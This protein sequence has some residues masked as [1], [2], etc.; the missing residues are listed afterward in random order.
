M[1]R[2]NERLTAL[3]TEDMS[4]LQAE[5]NELSDLQEIL[6]RLP[7]GLQ[8]EALSDEALTRLREVAADPEELLSGPNLLLWNNVCRLHN[9]LQRQS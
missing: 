3:N 7:L 4:R 6:N 1:A 5:V 9:G 8:V 2:K